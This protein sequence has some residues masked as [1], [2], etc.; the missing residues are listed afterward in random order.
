MLS[1]NVSLAK[2]LQ[3]EKS[4]TTMFILYWV[5]KL[6]RIHRP[7]RF[8]AKCFQVKNHL[9]KLTF[10]IATKRIISR[11]W[12]YLSRAMKALHALYA[13]RF[14]HPESARRFAFKAKE[15]SETRHKFMSRQE[16]KKIVYRLMIKIFSRNEWEGTKNSNNKHYCYN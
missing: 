13:E 15:K 5:G 1:M 6:P 16:N 10:F 12:Y 11:E 7:R 9:R 14:L 4:I 3:E 2:S 8:W